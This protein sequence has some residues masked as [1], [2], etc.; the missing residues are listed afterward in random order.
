MGGDDKSE[1]E[2]RVGEILAL[3]AATPEYQFS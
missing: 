2:A 3:I 1:S